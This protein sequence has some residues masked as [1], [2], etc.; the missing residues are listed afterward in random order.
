MKLAA[1]AMVQ[2]ERVESYEAISKHLN[3]FQPMTIFDRIDIVYSNNQILYQDGKLEELN[4]D[5]SFDDLVAEGEHMSLRTTD[6]VTGKEIIY[7]AVPIIKG[8]HI[9]A[10]MIGIIN[11]E[12]MPSIFQT[13]AYDGQA[14]VTLA[15]YRDGSFVLDEWHEKLGNV[16]EM[17]QRTPLKGYEN[18]DLIDD[19][20]NGRT[21]VTKYVSAENGENSFMYYTPTN[22]FNWE[23]LVVAQ[24]EVVYKNAFVLKETLL[25]LGFFEGLLILI[26]FIWTIFTVNQLEKSKNE[27]EEKKQ[28]FENLSYTDTL[29]KLFNRNKYNEVTDY[30]QLNPPHSMGVALLDL[31]GL[32]Q[33]NDTRGH[34][35]GDALIQDAAKCLN[36]I[37]PNQSYRIGGDEFVIL[38]SDLEKELFEERM[39]KLKILMKEKKVSISMGIIWKEEANDVMSQLREADEQM[40][41][42][43]KRYYRDNSQHHDNRKHRDQ[44]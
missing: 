13:N 2:E 4:A 21:G 40:Y 16:Y 5:L 9:V 35:I 44:F 17:K 18:V 12:N 10:F 19:I 1:N 6:A 23:M 8:D 43:K 24:E 29:T 11:C 33:I 32:K 34:K 15:D 31:N 38:V 42:Q 14:I 26:Y 30:Y 27:I 3:S 20:R 41:E 39:Q 37:F 7:Y 28:Q 36:M 22:I 25:K